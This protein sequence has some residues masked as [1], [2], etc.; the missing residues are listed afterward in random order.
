MI[1]IGVMGQAQAGKDTLA[2]HLVK[3]YDFVRIA[4]ADPI[5]RSLKQWYDF[6]DEQLWGNDKEKPD[7]RY[8]MLNGGGH[9]TARKAAQVTG[10][11][12]GRLAWHDTWVNRLKEDAKLVMH[13]GY[14]YDK[15]TGPV[16]K[17]W[18]KKAFSVPR[19]GIVVSD[20]RFKNEV[21]SIQNEPGGYVVR[22]KR[23]VATGNVGIIGH[24]SEMEQK[25]IPDEWL[26]VIEN[27][28][29]LEEYYRLI[30]LMVIKV[31]MGG[32]LRQRKVA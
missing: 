16:P 9:L 3:K 24:Q 12:V 25:E 30:D 1:I 5:K 13:K 26:H 23:N 18:L 8:P 11:E 22:V 19:K 6:T 28:G 20:V 14:D 2:D 27:N 7:F 4:L 29:T 17:S 10:T 31:M 21:A 15:K 32:G